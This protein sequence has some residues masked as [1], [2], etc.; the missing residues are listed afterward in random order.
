VAGDPDPVDAELQDAKRNPLP[1]SKVA[2]AEYAGPFF[3]LLPRNWWQTPPSSWAADSRPAPRQRCGSRVT[4]EMS[5]EKSGDF[6]KNRPE[7]SAIKSVDCIDV[8][9]SARDLQ[10]RCERNASQLPTIRGYARSGTGH[11]PSLL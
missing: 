7:L 5:R 2:S 6:A 11:V 3:C 10:K 1:G 8:D 4:V 9:R